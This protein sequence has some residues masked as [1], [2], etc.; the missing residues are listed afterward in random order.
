M[1]FSF[2]LCDPV[3]ILR[4][5]RKSFE[6]DG[7]LKGEII[8]VLEN[9]FSVDFSFLPHIFSFDDHSAAAEIRFSGVYALKDTERQ[10]HHEQR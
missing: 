7:G 4:R 1:I 9:L 8:A 10:H 2:Q 3:K 6:R 5:Y